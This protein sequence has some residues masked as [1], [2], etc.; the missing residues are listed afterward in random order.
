MHIRDRIGYT[1]TCC[2]VATVLLIS[3]IFARSTPPIRR[4]HQTLNLN[5]CCADTCR[6]RSLPQLT[7]AVHEDVVALSG[8]ATT[9]DNSCSR[10]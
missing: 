8:S 3:I 10:V 7:F 1:Y 2:D 6:D 9:T 5:S 4:L